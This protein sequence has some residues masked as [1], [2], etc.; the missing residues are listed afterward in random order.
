MDNG[1]RYGQPETVFPVEPMG[2]KEERKSMDKQ[3]H[4]FIVISFDEYE[5]I[6]DNLQRVRDILAI[7]GTGIS[8]E[9]IQRC[10]MYTDVS[11]RTLIE[12]KEQQS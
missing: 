5:E 12:E 10:I 6:T 4:G 2:M 7:H 8:N 3:K 9:D 1:Y 11:R